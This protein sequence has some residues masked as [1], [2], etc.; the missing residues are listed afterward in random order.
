MSSRSRGLVVEHQGRP[1]YAPTPILTLS[2]RQQIHQ[3]EDHHQVA[4]TPAPVIDAEPRVLA[5]TGRGTDDDNLTNR[6]AR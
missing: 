6:G 2:L 3:R 4:I 5:P 1:P